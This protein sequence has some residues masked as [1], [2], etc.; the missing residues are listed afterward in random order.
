RRFRVGAGFLRRLFKGT[1]M[2]VD[3]N[4]VF[5]VRPVVAG[6]GTSPRLHAFSGSIE[7]ED[8]WYRTGLLRGRHLSGR[9]RTHTLSCQSTA[10]N[11]TIPTTQLLGSFGGHC[12]DGSTSN[13]RIPARGAVEDSPVVRPLQHRSGQ[14]GYDGQTDERKLRKHLR[15]ML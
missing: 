1:T 5:H 12:Q 3:G 15:I 7:L 4:P 8:G 11:E 2:A 14:G 9:C 13:R 6:T 10:T